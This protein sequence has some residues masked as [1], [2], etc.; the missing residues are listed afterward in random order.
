MRTLFKLLM[1]IDAIGAI[2]TLL[3]P[4]F[5]M[6]R[7]EANLLGFA[8]MFTVLALYDTRAELKKFRFLHQMDLALIKNV[9]HDELDELRRQVKFGLMNNATK[10][11]MQLFEKYEKKD[12]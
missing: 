12:G 2:D 6:W 7:L 4:E 1:L 5:N 9:T 10:Y 3:A 11:L 8:L